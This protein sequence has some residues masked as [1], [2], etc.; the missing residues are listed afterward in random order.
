M[1]GNRVGTDLGGSAA[2]PN[3]F[4]GIVLDGGNGVAVD[5]NTVSGNLFAGID[6][7]AITGAT[8]RNNLVGLN[9]AGTAL[10]P[11]GDAGIGLQ[12]SGHFVDGNTVAGNLYGIYLWEGASNNFITNN[13]IGTDITGSVL[14][15]N[16]PPDVL[17]AGSGIIFDAAS[18]NIARGN[19]VAGHE[20]AGIIVG[21]WYS[22]G[23]ATGNA[24][25][26]NRVYANDSL[27]IDLA[28][29]GVT[30]NDAGDGD[31]GYNDLQNFPDL[32]SAIDGGGSTT[33]V[34]SLNSTPSTSFACTSMQIRAAIRPATA[35]A[36]HCLAPSM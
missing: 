23:T 8:I 29:D 35:R 25:A 4:E 9:S 15:G 32:T 36:K 21:E 10:V 26:D 11:N 20:A 27:G 1:S 24:F 34:G 17:S 13:R 5:A 3:R 31:N 19:I 18:N 6:L 16:G 30:A 33:I 7:R 14:F 22:V 2:V 28:K 12:G